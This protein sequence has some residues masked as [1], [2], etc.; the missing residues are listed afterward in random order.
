VRG[1]PLVK[2]IFDEEQRRETVGVARGTKWITVG[3]AAT[4]FVLAATT[5]SVA[6]AMMGSGNVVA[7]YLAHTNQESKVQKARGTTISRAVSLGKKQSGLAPTETQIKSW[8]DAGLVR[9][10]DLHSKRWEVTLPK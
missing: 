5:G 9:H 8:L 2:Q 7:A 10:G 1:R 3:L 4:N 6:S